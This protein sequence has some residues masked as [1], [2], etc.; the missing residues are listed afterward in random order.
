MNPERA[1]CRV[2][3]VV[4]FKKGRPAGA[5]LAKVEA[6]MK[7]KDLVIAV[8]LGMSGKGMHRV[9]TCDLSR[10]YIAINADYHT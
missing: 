1:V 10:E 9:Y 7:E 6:V 5:D 3:R 2:G 8:D 4:V